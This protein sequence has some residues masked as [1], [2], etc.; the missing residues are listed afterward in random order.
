MGAFSSFLL[1]VIPL[2]IVNLRYRIISNIFPWRSRWI[3]VG[4]IG[5][6]LAGIFV[7]GSRSSW[8]SLAVVLI[9]SVG[10]SISAL[11]KYRI[12]L[13]ATLA[14]VIGLAALPL[15]KN[16]YSELINLHE[17]TYHLR[18][19]AI[20]VAWQQF[21]GS[22]YMGGDYAELPS[23]IRNRWLHNAYLALLLGGGSLGALPVFLFILIALLR[24]LQVCTNR[25]ITFA[26]KL[27]V[28][29]LMLGI[30]GSLIEWMA[31]GKIFNIA[32]WVGISLLWHTCSV[33]KK[34]NEDHLY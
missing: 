21:E 25:K 14:I 3:T 6:L 5:I 16:V 28:L 32:V 24:G 12:V 26:H 31:Y 1:L 2:L 13:L 8:I 30:I 4:I 22:S 15:L 18:K 29:S 9:G 10:L 34:G 19:E 20:Q 7:T 17:S 11:N 33:V 27:L 23:F